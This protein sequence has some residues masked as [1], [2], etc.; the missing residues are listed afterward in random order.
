MIVSADK[1]P[2]I[3]ALA[4]AMVK[5][6]KKLDLKLPRQWC[7]FRPKVHLVECKVETL[8]IGELRATGKFPANWTGTLEQYLFLIIREAFQAG[9]SEVS[10]GMPSRYERPWVI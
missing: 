8:M 10:E 6:N 4:L 7:Q 1:T 2:G 3:F 9:G 5:D